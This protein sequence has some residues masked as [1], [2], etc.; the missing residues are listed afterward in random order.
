MGHSWLQPTPALRVS[1]HTSIADCVRL[2]RKKNV[3]S[4]LIHSP[5]QPDELVGIFT[6]RDLLK[7]VDEIQHGG[8]WDKPVA[9]LMSKPVVSLSLER[10][11]EAANLMLKRGI[12]HLPI[13]HSGSGRRQQLLGVVSMRDLL[14]QSQEQ[15]KKL[16]ATRSRTRN[17]RRVLFLGDGTK[18]R[19]FQSQSLGRW[20]E[21]TWAGTRWFTKTLTQDLIRSESFSESLDDWET[22]DLLI[23]DLDGLDVR[24][25]THFLKEMNRRKESPPVLLL[26]TEEQHPESTRTI[27]QSLAK[28]GKWQAF[29][30]PISLLSF[31]RS[32]KNALNTD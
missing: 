29:A 19:E 14:A 15:I 1:S 10:L 18:A 27:L 32:V 2:M 31:M 11:S 30:K 28:G 6:E 4:L 12:R 9:H 16:A 20:V 22:S 23:L 17:K 24:V 3:G 21:N 5:S 8:H 13:T 7:W 26:F 25:W